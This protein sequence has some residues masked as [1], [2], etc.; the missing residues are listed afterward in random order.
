MLN[1]VAVPFFLS[2]IFGA[3]D[4]FLIILKPSV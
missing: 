3:A 4:L 1:V 2:Q